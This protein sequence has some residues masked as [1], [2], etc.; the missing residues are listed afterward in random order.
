VSASAIR[1]AAAPVR[2][3]PHRART[4]LQAAGGAGDRVR[5][6]AAGRIKTRPGPAP[7]GGRPVLCTGRRSPSSGPVQGGAYNDTVA[8]AAAATLPAAI[9]PY[10]SPCQPSGPFNFPSQF[11]R[12]WSASDGQIQNTPI[13]NHVISSDRYRS[14]KVSSS[15]GF[16]PCRAPA[17]AAAPHP[18]Y[19]IAAGQLIGASLLRPDPFAAAF[20]FEEVTVLFSALEASH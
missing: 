5:V 17:G 2:G 6:S 3:P 4:S 12:G 16:H 10:Q 7:A 9:A 8:P 13:T 15:G 11:R 20:A 18:P 1:C 19:C 14:V